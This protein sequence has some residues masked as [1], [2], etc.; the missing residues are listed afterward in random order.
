MHVLTDVC[1]SSFL[2]CSIFTSLG[3][4]KL[5]TIC[6]PSVAASARPSGWRFYAF[7]VVY[8]QT[9][10]TAPL[11]V[12]FATTTTTIT[13]AITATGRP[14]LTSLSLSQLTGRRKHE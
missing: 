4:K 5:T 1:S 12:A 9:P 6:K 10:K 11:T 2:P 8:Q 14:A 13:P 7:S 3:T